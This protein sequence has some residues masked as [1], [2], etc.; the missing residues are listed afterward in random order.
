MK[1]NQAKALALVLAHE[2][3]FIHHPDDPG[4]ATN[5]G[6][7]QAVYD[8]FRQRSGQDARSVREITQAEVDA[9]YDQ[10]YW[11]RVNGDR[12]PSGIDYAVFDYAVNSGVSKATKDLQRALGVPADGIVGLNT[13]VA[14]G[15]CDPAAIIR[16]LCDRRMRFLRSL[17][18]WRTFGRGWTS[19]VNGV[20]SSALAMVQSQPVTV[21]L[22]PIGSAK[23]TEGSQALTKTKGVMGA[24]VNASGLSGQGV[25]TAAEQIKPQIGDSLVGRVA[26]VIFLIMMLAGGLLMAWTFYQ[27]LKEKGVL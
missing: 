25:L 12:L 27:R 18:T 21:S 5:K 9:I 22:E 11:D 16:D 10:Q 23:A 1:A 14:A 2:G 8:A 7:T 15:E 13:L 20:R 3:G 6:V 19:R 4:G 24:I 17:K 26:G